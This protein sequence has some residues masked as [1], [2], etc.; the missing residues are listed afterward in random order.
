MAVAGRDGHDVAGY[1]NRGVLLVGVAVAQ[2]AGAVAAHGPQGAVGFHKQGVGVTRRDGD[3]VAGYGDRGVLG[4]GVALAQLAI[5][6]VAPGLEQGV[7]HAQQ[8]GA[9]DEHARCIRDRQAV[10]AGVGKLEG[11][12]GEGAVG[13]AGEAGAVLEPLKGRESA[14]DGCG[15]AGGL[16]DGHDPAGGLGGEDQRRTGDH[17]RATGAGEGIVGGAGAVQGEGA[18]GSDGARAGQGAGQRGR[19]G[20][21]G[22]G[23]AGERVGEREDGGRRDR[24]A[25]IQAGAGEHGG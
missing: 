13:L 25:V 11:G 2:L 21:D 3:G 23:I 14:R 24:G 17:D 18:Q 22:H 20:G 16:A 1:V 19:A 9:A 6:G 7:G 10:T 4:E 12:E 5:I 8:R 15:E